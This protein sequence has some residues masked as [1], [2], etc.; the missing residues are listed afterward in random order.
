MGLEKIYYRGNRRMVGR[1][2]SDRV[3]EEARESCK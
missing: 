3:M 2:E 1:P